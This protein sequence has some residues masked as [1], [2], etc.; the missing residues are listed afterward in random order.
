M[1]ALEAEASDIL[2][3]TMQIRRLSKHQ[4]KAVANV[5]AGIERMAYREE[6]R[7]L[8]A[9][10][11]GSL[12]SCTVTLRD[13][14]VGFFG[15]EPKEDI[16]LL[17]GELETEVNYLKD[18]VKWLQMQGDGASGPWINALME[19]RALLEEGKYNEA[20]ENTLN[21]LRKREPYSVQRAADIGWLVE[22]LR[23]QL[24]N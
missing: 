24:A 20:S 9:K 14:A 3:T 4:D 21:L 7:P 17:L 22:E 16:S 19:L 6:L 11:T 12:E 2:L 1:L 15:K 5:M 18:Y 23:S 13:D 10:C 8:I